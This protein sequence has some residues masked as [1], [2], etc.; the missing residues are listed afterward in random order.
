MKARQIVFT[1]I[2]KAELIDTVCDLPKDNE[3]MV[4]VSYTAISCGT[5]KANFSGDINVDASRKTDDNIPKF[6]RYLG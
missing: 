3:V 6:P 1:D 2:K 4:K 5:E